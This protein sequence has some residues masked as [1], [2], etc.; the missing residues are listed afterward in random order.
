MG[1]YNKH[2][3][4]TDKISFKNLTGRQYEILCIIF[5]IPEEERDYIPGRHYRFYKVNGSSSG[6]QIPSYLDKKENGTLTAS[7]EISFD[8]FEY[9]YKNN[10]V[11]ISGIHMIVEKSSFGYYLYNR[12]DIRKIFEKLNIKDRKEFCKVYSSDTGLFPN[13]QTLEDLNRTIQNLKIET[14]SQ[15]KKYIVKKKYKEIIDPLIRENFV[16]DSNIIYFSKGSPVHNFLVG[17]DLMDL[18]EEYD[19]QG[20]KIFTLNQEC[21]GSFDLEVSKKGIRYVPE[22]TLLSSSK[23]NTTLS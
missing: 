15:Y 1:R 6:K 3:V 17:K 4:L 5:E 8:E 22:N 19:D 16:I 11:T 9:F 20:L 13:H 18:F 10:S 7:K 23:L 2:D 12:G 21:G 14:M